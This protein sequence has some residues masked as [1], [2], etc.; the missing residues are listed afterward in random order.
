MQTRSGSLYKDVPV[1]SATLSRWAGVTSTTN[2]RA[3]RSA[4]ASRC[5]SV[6]GA[7]EGAHV[8]HAAEVQAGGNSWDAAGEK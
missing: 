3:S 8:L 5:F 6:E 1:S 2:A 7:E 4:R